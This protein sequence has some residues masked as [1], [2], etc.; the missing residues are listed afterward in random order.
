M[1]AIVPDGAATP[2]RRARPWEADIVATIGGTPLVAL[3]RLFPPERFRVYA[4]CECFN[5]G[6]SIKDRAAKSMIEQ[7]LRAGRL[8]PGVSTIV[9][10]TSGNLGIALAQ[11]CNFYRLNLICVVDPRTTGQNL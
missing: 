10:S 6:G 3:D 9:E 4:K 11:L 5:P 1:T 8:L 2:V 7:A